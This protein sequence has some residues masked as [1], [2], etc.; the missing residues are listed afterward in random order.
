MTADQLIAEA[1]AYRTR[2]PD[3]PTIEAVQRVLRLTLEHLVEGTDLEADPESL[4]ARSRGFWPTLLANLED[5]Q[6]PR[7]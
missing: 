7:H 3:P 1:R 5:Q 4:P 2:Q 6:A